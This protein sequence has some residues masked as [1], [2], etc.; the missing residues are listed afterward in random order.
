[1]KAFGEWGQNQHYNN[2]V[3][4]AEAV[5]VAVAAVVA[6]TVAVAE[7]DVS[8]F[9]DYNYDMELQKLREID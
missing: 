4:G 1:M 7:G 6:A 3:G 2:S 8:L 9:G 5:V